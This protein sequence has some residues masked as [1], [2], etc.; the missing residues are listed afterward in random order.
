MSTSRSQNS[1]AMKELVAGMDRSKDPVLSTTVTGNKDQL[2]AELDVLLRYST[3]AGA[4]DG[5]PQNQSDHWKGVQRPLDRAVSWHGM[6]S[7][8]GNHESGHDGPNPK[9]TSGGSLRVERSKSV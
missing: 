8:K 5:R 7:Y 2:Q 6:S 9:K 3:K 4:E 1:R